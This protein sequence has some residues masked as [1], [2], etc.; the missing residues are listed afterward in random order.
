LH[1]GKGGGAWWI[2][3]DLAGVLWVLVAATGLVLWLQ[4]KKRRRVG[5]F[6]LV[7]GTAAGALLFVLL[8][9]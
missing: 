3:I 6:W 5:A 7:V 4:L 1:T 2:A 9:P 8:A